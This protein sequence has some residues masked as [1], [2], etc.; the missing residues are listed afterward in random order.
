ME[1]GVM[2]KFVL[3]KIVFDFMNEVFDDVVF[4]FSDLK[5]D[6]IIV[7]NMMIE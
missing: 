3:L 6:G 4:I 1:V 2:K 7:M 5:L